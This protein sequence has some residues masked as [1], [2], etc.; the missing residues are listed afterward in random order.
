MTP[1]LVRMPK[2]FLVSISDLYCLPLFACQ[3]T[4]KGQTST[5][6]NEIW[7]KYEGTPKSYESNGYALSFDIRSLLHIKLTAYACYWGP[8]VCIFVGDVDKHKA[9]VLDGFRGMGSLVLAATVANTDFA[10]I[11][12]LRQTPK[13][14]YLR[15]T[16]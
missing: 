13:I 16:Y 4:E 5:S 10:D 1:L 6:R 7:E 9:K 3:P 11:A 2:A 14:W 15:L 8:E 12:S